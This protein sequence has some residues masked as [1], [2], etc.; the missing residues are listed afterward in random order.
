MHAQDVLGSGAGRGKHRAP[1][2]RIQLT[3]PGLMWEGDGNDNSMRRARTGLVTDKWPNGQSRWPPPRST[4]WACA[5][6]PHLATWF[7]VSLPVTFGRLT[8]LLPHGEVGRRT[9]RSPCDIQLGQ[10]AIR[11]V[12]SSFDDHLSICQCFSSSS[13]PQRLLV[14]GTVMRILLS[15]QGIT[16]ALARA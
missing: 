3:P 14:H 15:S 12:C 16:S 5:P 11:W 2:P 1:V 6:S 7:V 4:P 8:S 10:W 13:L 9:P